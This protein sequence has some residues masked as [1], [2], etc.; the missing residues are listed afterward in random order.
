LMPEIVTQALLWG[1]LLAFSTWWRDGGRCLA[2]LAGLALGATAL[3]RVED[4]ILVPL[5]IALFLGWSDRRPIGTATFAGAFFG[6]I[7][8]A[9]AR[10]LVVPTH[11]RDALRVHALLAYAALAPAAGMG[12]AVAAIVVVVAA[13]RRGVA[14]RRVGVSFVALAAVVLYA[15]RSP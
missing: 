10:F 2:L 13:R 7:A 1:G 9:F 8:W 5:A 3:A 14:L 11:Y 4:L 6:V 15:V 12:F